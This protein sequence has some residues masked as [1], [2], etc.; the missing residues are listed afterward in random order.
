MCVR[1]SILLVLREVAEKIDLTELDIYYNA[2]LELI[3]E[4]LNSERTTDGKSLDKGEGIII[5]P[6]RKEGGR[7][8][9]RF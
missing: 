3:S 4:P 8:R 2:I 6:A 7:W 1:V 9:S 5:W